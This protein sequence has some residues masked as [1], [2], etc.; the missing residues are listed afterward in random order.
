MLKQS[1]VSEIN[2]FSK[3]P[4]NFLYYRDSWS[5]ATVSSNNYFN[6]T[7]VLLEDGKGYELI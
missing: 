7:R 1:I 2:I 3:M 5:L 4:Y 6:P